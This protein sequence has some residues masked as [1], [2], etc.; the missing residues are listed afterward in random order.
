MINLSSFQSYDTLFSSL[1]QLTPLNA[2]GF[3]NVAGA[4]MAAKYGKSINRALSSDL[5]AVMKSFRTDALEL[6]REAKK[7][8]GQTDRSAL[9]AKDNIADG[10]TT[11]NQFKNSSTIRVDQL[12]SKQTNQGTLLTAK[13][14]TTL[15]TGRY[16]IAITR[17]NKNYGV[18]INIQAGE[19]NGS[20]LSKTAKAIN[21]LDSGVKARVASDTLG[22]Q[23]LIIESDKTGKENGFTVSGSLSDSLNL[24]QVALPG[25][26]AKFNY[27][28]KDMET[29]S[30]AVTLDFGK[31]Q[32]A[33]KATSAS[34]VTLART[35]DTIGLQENV[36]ALVS[37]YN[38]FQDT[39]RNNSENRALK[40]FNQQLDQ[41]VSKET[42]S[43]ERFG[44][45]KDASGTLKI[46]ADQLEKN[47]AQNP[48][49]ARALFVENGGLADKL[50][51][52]TD[53]LLKTPAST[54]LNLP[55]T[56]GNAPSYQM[57]NS[58]FVNQ[59]GISAQ[60]SGNLFDLLL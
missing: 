7:L 31:T 25:A 2:S 28:G 37:A 48:D 49:E 30:N 44:I 27:N 56:P 45:T 15:D 41:L 51:S 57:M 58:G 26:N 21:G 18:S 12:A 39:L 4:Y 17:N 50:K 19:S 32:L 23:Q 36:T 3:S 24:N 5:S 55:K 8:T 11:N 46:D 9:I 22:N 54:L 42:G 1:K 34:A 6:N 60:S 38:R 13:Q 53:Q 59:L 47:L 14:K 35:P 40:V 29:D 16:E 10:F 20:V 52:R 43:L 33:L